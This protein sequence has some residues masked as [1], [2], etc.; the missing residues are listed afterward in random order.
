VEETC[1]RLAKTASPPRYKLIRYR[2]IGVR[3]DAAARLLEPDD[4]QMR[5]LAAVC[6]SFGIESVIA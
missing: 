4:A 2:P 5:A 3:R 1:R 6:D